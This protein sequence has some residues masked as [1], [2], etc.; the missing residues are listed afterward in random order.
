[1]RGGGRGCAF[2]LLFVQLCSRIAGLCGLVG[3][4]HDLREVWRM[5]VLGIGRVVVKCGVQSRGRGATA[6]LPPG[7]AVR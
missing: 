3:W 7:R 6:A 5:G 1:M 4:S 2:S